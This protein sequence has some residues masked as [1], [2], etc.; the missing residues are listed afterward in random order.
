MKDLTK[1]FIDLSK[2]S[3]EQRKS[4]P[5]ILREA[6]ELICDM[7]ENMLNSGGLIDEDGDGDFVLLAKS[8]NKWT[9]YLKSGCIGRTEVTYPEFIKLFEGGEEENNGW[10]KIEGITNEIKVSGNLWVVN[11]YGAIEFVD[12]LEYIPLGYVTHYQPILKPKPPKF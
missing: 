6:G 7:T 2:L 1:Y 10:I 4:L 8:E 11:K 12:E 3:E 5:R 9:G